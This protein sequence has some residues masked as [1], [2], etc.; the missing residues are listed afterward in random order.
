V[1]FVQNS[2]PS[3]L[4]SLSAM[5]ETGTSVS[6]T[7]APELTLGYRFSFW[8]MDGS[9]QRDALGHAFNPVR[10]TLLAPTTA[11]AWYRL[12]GEDSNTNALPD[13][14]ELRYS[15]ALFTNAA[16]DAD[17]DG[18]SLAEEYRRD[19]HPNLRDEIREGGLSL[20]FSAP[21]LAIPD[22][23]L[24]SFTQSS[25]PPGLVPATVSVTN[26]GATFALPDS[27]GLTNGYRFVGWTLHGTVQTDLLGRA[28]GG[29][30]F[31]L[32]SNTSAQALFA[33]ADDDATTNGIPDWFELHFYGAADLEPALDSDADG[34]DLAEEYRRDYHPNLRD[35]IREGGLSLGFS[36]PTLVVP[37]TNLASYASGSVPAGLVPGASGVTNL[38]TLLALPDGFGLTN[39]Y[40]F[41]GWT[42]NGTVQTD[43]LGRA[44]GGLTFA[45]AGNSLAQALFVLA[46][47][48]ATTN[49]IP[50]WFEQH[51]YGADDLEPTLDT[52]GD[53][54]GLLEEYRRDYHPNLRDE[55][56]EGGLSLGFSA[57]TLVMPDTNLASY[58]RASLPEGLV[59]AASGVTN[60]GAL[61]ALPDAF[62]L[63]NGYRFVGWSLNGVVQTDQLGRA[64]GSLTFALAGN[65][66]A[67]ALFVLAEEDAAANAV[68]D[69]FERHFYGVTGLEP[70]LD[71][72]A[73]GFD[74]REE[75]RRDY[76]PN[77]RDEI[78]E[79]GLSLA[80]SGPAAVSFGFYDRVQ[81]TLLDGRSLALFTLAPPATGL[82]AVAANS[83]PALG[84]WDG[85][86]DLDLF[87][88]GSNGSMRIFE[89]AG[90]P[91]V[92]NLVERT[93]NFT[94]LA[95]AWTNTVNPAPA[96]GDW[97]GDGRADLAVGGGTGGV[98]FV[99]SPGSFD[100]H[101]LTGTLQT[102]F[103]V[104]PSGAIPAFLDV[105][106]DARP[107]LLL[108]SPAGLVSAYT[109]THTPTL[110]YSATPF[111]TNLLGTAVPAATGLTTA[112]INGDGVPDVLVSDQNG[113]IWE[114]HG[115]GP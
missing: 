55:I 78:R 62:G 101:A 108:L 2:E 35:E 110:P 20:G 88:G 37:D 68:P 67:Q 114:F 27:F 38:G 72:D 105:N 39:G 11:T 90:S 111:S 36:A 29:L 31:A 48:D 96:L 102:A 53:G 44:H 82:L 45:L 100:M 16:A 4:V 99:A 3:G 28:R 5:V 112:D 10:F 87:I 93:S 69:W 51:F 13:W 1:A 81:S 15:D 57:L 94:A 25:T 73:D 98:W 6:T 41:V 50:D 43:L 58:A 106:H 97:S 52:D 83:H 8:R 21:T 66:L 91:R 23:N 61:L 54:F 47:D 80:F 32:A 22:T 79:G 14:W 17:A 24:A 109:N 59:P 75:Y 7:N 85:D 33:L 65:S 30:P 76:H 104:A 84:D 60:L 103:V 70:G 115:A 92:L 42:L 89:N 107:D 64:R 56:R 113:N 49:G 40:R 86:G 26:L 46:G 12:E 71:T 74:L 63:T 9:A 77:L 19:Y 95:F 34:F 18:F